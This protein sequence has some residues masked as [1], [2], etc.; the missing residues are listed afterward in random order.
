MFPFRSRVPS[1]VILQYHILKH[2]CSG[3]VRPSPATQPKKVVQTSINTFLTSNKKARVDPSSSKEAMNITP[4]QYQH[5][6]VAPGSSVRDQGLSGGD[7]FLPDV[8]FDLS[9]DMDVFDGV[10]E[11]PMESKEISCTKSSFSTALMYIFL[12]YLPNWKH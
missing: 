7:A 1:L 8:D 12:I 9:S 4:Q 3:K 5:G 2:L 6:R 10:V 11:T